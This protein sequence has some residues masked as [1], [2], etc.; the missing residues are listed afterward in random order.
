QPT[1]QQTIT[2]QPLNTTPQDLTQRRPPPVLP[3]PAPTVD[4]QVNL[5]M[6]PTAVEVHIPVGGGHA[7]AVPRT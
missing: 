6:L 3:S 4:A 2:Q 1:E 5:H 7:K